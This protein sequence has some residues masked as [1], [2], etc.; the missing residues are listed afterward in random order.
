MVEINQSEKEIIV[1]KLIEK[2]DIKEIPNERK[3]YQVE[4]TNIESSKEIDK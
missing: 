4:I 1:Q 2:E 3:L